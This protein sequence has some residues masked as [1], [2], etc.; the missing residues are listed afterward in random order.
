MRIK[1]LPPVLN[2]F[3]ILFLACSGQTFAKDFHHYHRWQLDD[4]LLSDTL[5]FAIGH[6]GYGDN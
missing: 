6:R 2:L 5:P 1:S 4:V 3:L